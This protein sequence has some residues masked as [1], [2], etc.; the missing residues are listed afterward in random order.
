MKFNIKDPNSKNY[1]VHLDGILQKN[2]IEADTDLGKVKTLVISHNGWFGSNEVDTFD[3]KYG[4]VHI[5]RMEGYSIE[6]YR[7]KKLIKRY[8][9]KK[10]DL[11][12]I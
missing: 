4:R 3:V 7:D 10:D 5:T 11:E 2:A 1:A 12:L 9:E 8:Y 6:E